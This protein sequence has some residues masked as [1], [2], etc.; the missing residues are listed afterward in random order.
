MRFMLCK[1][2]MCTRSCYASYMLNILK[3]KVSSLSDTA[4]ANLVIGLA[5]VGSVAADLLFA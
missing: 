5:I 1:V 4:F 2:A 3:A